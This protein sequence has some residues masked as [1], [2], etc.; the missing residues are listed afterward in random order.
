MFSFS[1]K[2]SGSFLRYIGRNINEKCQNEIL[3]FINIEGAISGKLYFIQ[4]K[5]ENVKFIITK[6][7]LK[8]RVD[9]NIIEKLPDNMFFV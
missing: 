4:P 3:D 7:E 5:D 8:S 1:T 9:I 2:K 6:E